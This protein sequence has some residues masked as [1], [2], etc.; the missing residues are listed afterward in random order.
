MP[1]VTRIMSDRN[2]QTRTGSSSSKRSGSV[3]PVPPPSTLTPE[4][5]EQTFEPCAATGSFLLY[6]QRNII[7]VLHHDTLVIERRFERHREDIKWIAVDNVSE[8]GAGRIAV[9]YDA[10][11]STVVW[12][13]LTGQEIA[14]FVA[15]D[16][17]NVAHFMRNGNIAFG[18]RLKMEM[19]PN[20][21][22]N[23]STGNIQGTIILFEP[24]TDENICARTIFDPITAI[25]PASDNRTFA[26]GY[27]FPQWFLMALLTSPGTLMV[28]SLSRPSSQR[29]RFYTP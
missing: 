24:S 21:K 18:K 7:L 5:S 10:G 6:S 28:P 3:R 16:P 4:N 9:S 11:H 13:I 26:I 20:L 29:L 25:A 15:Y 1:T 8:Q 12:D 27:G 19:R 22:A 17:I 23:R 2:S 14:R